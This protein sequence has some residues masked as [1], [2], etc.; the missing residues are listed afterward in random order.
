MDQTTDKRQRK[1][2]NKNGL[3]AIKLTKLLP[4]LSR[5]TKAEHTNYQY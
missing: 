3:P 4:A 5:R 2:K 1:F